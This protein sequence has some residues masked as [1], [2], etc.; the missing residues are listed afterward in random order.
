MF[1]KPVPGP[2]SWP[3]ASAVLPALPVSVMLGRRLAVATPICAL[4]ACRLA[5]AWSTSGRC[6]TSTEG[7]LSGSSAGSVRL[8][9]VNFCRRRLAGKVPVRTAIRLCCWSR[10]LSSG[11]KRR[12]ELG[13]LRLLGGDV[14]P[15]DIALRLLILEKAEDLAVD[16]DQ[17]VGRRDLVFERGVLDRGWA[18]LAVSVM[19]TAI[20]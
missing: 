5:W 4:A 12:L 10:C 16:P 18:T 17:L 6:S 13:E 19:S 14:G 8:A 9:S 2:N 20:I 15:A 3:I 1:Q 11:G 7:R